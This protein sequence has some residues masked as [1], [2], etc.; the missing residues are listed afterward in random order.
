MAQTDYEKALSKTKVK[1]MSNPD[2]TFFLTVCLSL[3]NVWDS[4]IQ[5]ACTDGRSITFNPAFF[6]GLDE[7]ERLFLLLHET[8]HVAYMHMAR[9]LGRD[10]RKWNIAADY[11]INLQLVDRGY[12]LPKEGLFDRQWEG[13]SVEEVYALLPENPEE[14]FM[15][16]L[17]PGDGSSAADE[18]LIQEIQEIV[19]RASLASKMAGDKPG[20][21][22]GDIEI[23]LNKLLNPVLPW[24]RLLIRHLNSYAKADYSFRKFNRRFFPKFYLP[25]L[26][27]ECLKDLVIAVDTSGSV[28]DHDFT[29]FISEVASIL[30]MMKPA[31]ITLIQ[32]DTAIKSVDSVTDL[33][34]LQQCKFTGRGGTKI[35]P[36]MEWAEE[37]KPQLLLVFSDG[38]FRPAHLKP[39][40]DLLWII[41]NNQSFQAPFGKV[42]HYTI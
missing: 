23:F 1:L 33:K 32:F 42:I 22:P 31:K 8:L 34:S 4:S 39:P 7:D 21:I 26:H 20:S 16:D 6:M 27:S 13:K 41:H 3:K 18:K 37:N 5:T 38:E 30:R 9:L 28:S 14:S 10:P 25:T 40:G 15:K 36:V 35:H 29:V 24:N 19:V 2:S 11:V 12:K 17:V